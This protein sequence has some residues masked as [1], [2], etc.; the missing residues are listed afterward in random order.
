[1]NLAIHS[2][3][4]PLYFQGG[5]ANKS[6]KAMKS[7]P[8]SHQIRKQF[9]D[10]FEQ[11][12]HQVAE[13]YTLVPQNDPTLLFTN[14]GMV[15]FKDYFTNVEE[16]PTKQMA[17]CQKCVRAGGKH[18]DLENVGFTARHH[19]FFEMLGNFSFGDYFKEGAIK[20]AWTFLTENL[21]L[22][23]EKLWVTVFKGTDE[24]PADEEAYKLWHE[25]IGVP[26]ERILRLGMKDN[27]WAMGDTGP[28][29]PCS[30]ILYD[31]GPEAS[32][33]PDL[34]PEDDG[35]RY[36]EIWNLVFM[37]FD[38]D[39]EGTLHPLPAPCVDTGMGL[40]RI[41]AVLQGQL[42]NYH[43]DAFMP[44]LNEVAEGVG[45]KYG[46]SVE[47][48]ISIRAIADH[49]RTTAFLIAESVFPSPD[50]EGYVL[51][52]IM[53]RAIRHGK[54]LGYDEP[55][56]YK[57]CAKVVELMSDVYPELK[58]N[59]EVIQTVSKQ[60]EIGFRQTLDRGLKILSKAFDE[61][62]EQD[63]KVLSGKTAFTLYDTYGFPI[64]L[65]E[66]I[67]G[68]QGFSLDMEAF[69]VEQ[70]KAKIQENT[71]S[72]EG[73]EATSL[74]YNALLTEVGPSTFLGYSQ[75]E[76]KGTVQ[77]I[78]QNGQ[79]V[80]SVDEG[81]EVEVIVDQTPF[82][83]ESGGQTGDTG[84]F[85]DGN[86][87]RV[88]ITNTTKPEGK[89]FV[90]HGVVESGTLK[91]KMELQLEVDKERRQSIRLN[92][93]ATHLLH[94]AL[95]KHLG[96]HVKQKGSLVAPDRLRFD[97][98]HYQ[99]LKADEILKI[100]NEI[101][102]LIRNNHQIVTE[103]LS[104][105]E[106]KEAGAMALFGEKY[107]D[108]V[109]MVRMGPS[110]ELCGG[111]HA[112]FSGDIGHCRIVKEEGVASG[113]RR[114]EAL[115]GP[116]ADVQTQL[117]YQTLQQTSSMMSCR[118]EQLPE[119]LQKLQNE[120]KTLQ[121]QVEQLQIEVAQAGTAGGDLLDQA[122]EING[123]SFLAAKV[124][125]GDPKAIRELAD[126]LRDRMGKG[127]IVLGGDNNGKASLCAMVSK[128][129]SKQVH[130]GKLIKELVTHVGGKGGGRPDMAQGGGPDLQKLQTA[131]DAV[132][133]WLEQNV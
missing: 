109:R 67:C 2:R 22:N 83:G 6:P 89:L 50:K 74:D 11:Q 7:N 31:L 3:D 69:K 57:I 58:R 61:L 62:K 8:T 103:E 129:L 127:V 94:W 77:A 117:W 93:S 4:F 97:Y 27:F 114:I 80:S 98:A 92:H 52:R 26:E 82:Y 79:R 25:T 128:G 34:K 68:E 51:R 116:G 32:S 30:E 87:L 53:R 16:P 64:D 121:R 100:E 120:L 28:C 46:D 122:K 63:Q 23:P 43:T 54:K 56:F 78:L 59:E 105:D 20:H 33:G 112:S 86:G 5:R 76:T 1:M 88:R 36:L 84:A 106:A 95:R 66:I 21:K 10:Y 110:L 9:L 42:S 123:V 104:F 91:E 24:V 40:E 38:R 118:P 18:N 125:L 14:A 19:T 13:S 41:T 115:T 45:K 29:G 126:Q 48:D 99:P 49:A 37:Q 12:N 71:E 90:H 85:S 55:F 133:P 107:G 65:T 75:E 81:A 130:A 132:G 17:S 15:Q 60:E 102:E 72:A 70:E 101:N 47:E 39:K 131:L 96:D 73:E 35:E 44:L 113:T 124:G 108:K 119:R 111:T